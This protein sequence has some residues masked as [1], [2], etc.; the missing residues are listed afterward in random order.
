MVLGHVIAQDVDAT[1]AGLQLE[2]TVIG[3]KPAVEDLDDLE[4]AFADE[5]ATRRLLGTITGVAFDSNLAVWI[6]HGAYLPSPSRLRKQSARSTR[7]S[8]SSL[9]DMGVDHRRAHVVV[10]RQFLDGTDVVAAIDRSVCNFNG[11]QPPC[12]VFLLLLFLPSHR[13]RP[14]RRST[15]LPERCGPMAGR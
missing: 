11:G 9:E 4:L 1:M 6:A 15:T 12:T 2:I 14:A 7:K 5:K 3:G 10:A 13:Y 8:G